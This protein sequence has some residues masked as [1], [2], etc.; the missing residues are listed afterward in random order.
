M[1]ET[2]WPQHDRSAVCIIA[3]QYSS[4]TLVSWR[5]HSPKEK[6]GPFFKK[7]FYFNVLII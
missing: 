3:Q 1:L 5:S 2:D 7:C 4:N 6:L